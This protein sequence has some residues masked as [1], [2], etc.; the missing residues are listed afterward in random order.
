M[1]ATIRKHYPGCYRLSPPT[2]EEFG[3]VKRHGREWHAEI[4]FSN[5]DLKRYAGIW[6]TRRETV[7]EILS[8][9]AW[10]TP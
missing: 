5:G 6:N 3:Q 8:Y 10:M 2:D 1:Q 9:Y 4:R 7:E